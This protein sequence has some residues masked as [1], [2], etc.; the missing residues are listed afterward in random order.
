M[1]AYSFIIEL[2]AS[3]T[4]VLHRGTL[5]GYR[6]LVV[7]GGLV[8]AVANVCI[9]CS[10]GLLCQSKMRL[11]QGYESVRHTAESG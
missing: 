10:I 2:V 5:D 1:K 6:A 11:I 9:P 8:R 4:V 7:V 3:S